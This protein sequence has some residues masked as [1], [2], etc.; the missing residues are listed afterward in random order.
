MERND[1]SEA[2][3]G[4]GGGTDS[5]L[6]ETSQGTALILG[7]KCDYADYGPIPMRNGSYW[8]THRDLYRRRYRASTF[9]DGS[10]CAIR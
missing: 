2:F 10:R 4:T 3:N 5:F 7:G 1:D 9:S 8:T 6:C